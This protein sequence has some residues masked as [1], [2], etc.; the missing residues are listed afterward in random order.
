MLQAIKRWLRWPGSNPSNDVND[1]QLVADT[2]IER[3]DQD[4]LDRTPVAGRIAQILTAPSGRDGRVFAIRG[5]WGYGKSSLKNLV[6]EALE[7]QRAD[8]PVLDFNPWQWG[9]ND[10]IARA[11]FTQMASKLGG[12]H[13]PDATGR[14]RALRR[15]GGI[16]VGSGT[17]LNKFGHNSA[18]IASLLTG[19]A[20][21][22]ATLGFT[23][24]GVTAVTVSIVVIALAALAWILG[25]LLT[26]LGR[27]RSADGLDDIRSDLQQRLSALP[28]P[29]VVFV[30]DIDRLEPDQIRLI[31]RQI[32]ANASLPNINFV[33]LFQPSIVEEALNPVAGGDGREYL[34]KIVQASFDLPPVT[35]AKLLQIF[36]QQ[37]GA[38]V[39]PLATA[40]NGFHQT[41][42]GNALRGGIEPMI[43]N[44]RDSR[45]L[46]TSIA[47]HVEMHKGE[48]AFEV[49]I[50]D[51]LALETLRVFEPDFHRALGANKLLLTQ[52]GR[53]AG[54]NRNDANRAEV[55]ALLDLVEAARRPASERLLRELF[56]PIEWT[57]GGMH[58][59]I[60]DFS[61]DWLKAKRVCTRRNFDRYFELQLAGDV[62][63]ESDFAL[64]VRTAID[65]EKLAIVVASL[66]DRNLQ[67]PLAQRL[68]QSVNDLPLEQPALLL[69]LIFTNGE[70]LG[71][72]DSGPFN[73]PFVASWRSAHWYLR[74][75]PGSGERRSAFTEAFRSSGAM[76]VPA[77]ILSLQDKAMSEPDPQNS[78]IFTAEDLSALKALWLERMEE[79]AA[80]VD[81]QL[82]EPNLIA[83]LFRWQQFGGDE[84]P[85]EWVTMVGSSLAT[86][87]PLLQQFVNRGSS[88][89]I[90]DLV[91]TPTESFH[92]EHFEAFLPVEVVQQALDQVDR[93]NLTDVERKVVSLFER[94]VELWNIG[95]DKLRD[96]DP[97]EA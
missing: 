60:G 51:F 97:E 30:D 42:W 96:F 8:V 47:I 72:P 77:T 93:T 66:A 54:D 92:R 5:S 25:T 39:D 64:F 84:R 24:P 61:G 53:F 50:I 70:T 65:P 69:D 82:S 83:R 45:R 62:L 90:H 46:L 44:L 17:S 49:N 59:G 28:R 33:L 73:E 56:P 3:A 87:V 55:T 80:D 21:L 85:K 29:L 63:S 7:S 95:L 6:I 91:A 57:L 94:H 68:D 36:L 12:S 52:A 19:A 20:V 41:R 26:W 32:K 35:G 34:E 31:I 58:Y 89:S 40:E 67:A 88:Q 79:Q 10:A 13:S 76:A 11:L 16:F 78:P 38:M 71:R 48:H 14:A 81:R 74:R 4:L 18:G 22:A 9:D 23:L 15:Y 37:L 43:R 86:I 27:D 1:V 2:P 75:L